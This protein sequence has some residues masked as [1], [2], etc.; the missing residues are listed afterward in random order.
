MLIFTTPHRPWMQRVLLLASFLGLGACSN[1][2][3][4][5]PLSQQP[6]QAE[7]QICQY[8][9][10]QWAVGKTNTEAHITQARQRA[11]A[12]IVRVVNAGDPVTLEFNP[13]RLTL[14]INAQGRIVSARCG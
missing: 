14:E 12:Y 11:G 2:K 3:P 1:F 4:L 5:P 13:E 7:A 9:A 10:A 8:E 6:A